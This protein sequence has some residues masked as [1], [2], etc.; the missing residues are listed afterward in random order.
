MID[1]DWIRVFTVE[2]LET[3]ICGE[4]KINLY[5]WEENTEYKNYDAES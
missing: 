1:E 4:S 5:D 2:E 3:V